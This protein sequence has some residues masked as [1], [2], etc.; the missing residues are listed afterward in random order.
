MYP[1]ERVGK[2]FS[3]NDRETLSCL[4]VTWLDRRVHNVSRCYLTTPK[5]YNINVSVSI[6]HTS[7]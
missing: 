2:A 3:K 5:V 4:K 6:F 7:G 1:L